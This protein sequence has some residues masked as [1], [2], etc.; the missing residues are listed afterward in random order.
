ML[1]GG[2]RTAVQRTLQTGWGQA[3]R[4]QAI[5]GA[6]TWR[7]TDTKEAGE[8]LA[9]DWDDLN[10][11][12]RYQQVKCH[13][14]RSLQHEMTSIELG[15]NT[16]TP[17]PD[18]NVAIPHQRAR[19]AV[20]YFE[21]R[22]SSSPVGGRAEAL[23]EEWMGRERALQ[24]VLGDQ[25]KLMDERLGNTES[26][27]TMLR[28]LRALWP[29]KEDRALIGTVVRDLRAEGAIEEE[30]EEEEEKKLRPKKGTVKEGEGQLPLFLYAVGQL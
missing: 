1:L 15:V 14:L 8:T 12:I 13:A 28:A 26:T 19:N 29:T 25:K 20:A 2:I 5:R 3:G 18:A 21:S 10:N 17:L 9:I 23:A 22:P 7:V 24:T 27:M 6:C 4:R 11:Q 16:H 30:E